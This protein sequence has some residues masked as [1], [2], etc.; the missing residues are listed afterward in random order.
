MPDAR[1]D[2]GAIY[3]SGSVYVVGGW[4]E[5]YVKKAHIYNIEKDNWTKMPE[6]NDEREDVS[7]CVV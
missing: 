6:L 1:V 7:L 2:F 4:Q 5:F 3:F